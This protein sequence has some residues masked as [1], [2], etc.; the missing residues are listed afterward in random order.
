MDQEPK[1]N[2]VAEGSD[3]VFAPDEEKA[4]SDNGYWKV[5]IVDDEQEI[6]AVTEL[7]L[8][9][10]SFEAKSLQ[11]LH[12][13]SGAEAIRIIAD[14]PDIAVIFLDIVMES[15]DAGLAVAKSI[16][17]ELNNKTVRIILRTGQAELAP[18]QS[19]IV[20]YEISAYKSKTDLTAQKLFS[21][22]VGSL[23]S[24]RDLV[25]LE[26]YRRGL[27]KIVDSIDPKK[28]I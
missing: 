10:F 24:Y 8:R 9:N 21:T 5:L 12:A 2:S 20:A 6:H 4:A 28:L 7:A 11:F 1:R 26:G 3:V 13:Y 17:T 27:E 16:R 18:K 14:Q 23:R 22:V 15:D 25:A 19:I